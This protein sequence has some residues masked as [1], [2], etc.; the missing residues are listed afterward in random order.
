M[1]IYESHYENSWAICIG[2]NSYK[3]LSPLEFAVNDAEEIAKV[4]KEQFSFP[5]DNVKLLIDKNASKKQI[6]KTYLEL[7][8]KTNVN[9]KVIFFFAGHGHTVTGNR[10]EVGYL[11]PYDAT[12]NDLSSMIRWDEITKNS[13]LIPAKHILFLLDACF[14]G[15][16]ITR[17]MSSGNMRFVKDMLQRYSRQAL[18]AGKANQPVSDADGPI[19]HHS[20]FTGYLINGLKGEAK[21]FK[22]ILSANG[23]MHY[24]YQKVA[25]DSNSYQTPHYGFVD[26]DGDFIFHYPAEERKNDTKQE[27]ILFEV[28]SIS[29]QYSSNE[30]SFINKLKTY[31][32]ESKYLIKLD[33]LIT[34]ELKRALS[35]LNEANFKSTNGSITEEV[36]L[37]NIN[38]FE[39][40]LGNLQTILI[41]VSYW[42]DE[43]QKDL[44]LKIFSRLITHITN[45]NSQ[46]LWKTLR[47]YSVIWLLYSTGISLLSKNDLRT[48]YKLLSIETN[49]YEIDQ[50]DNTFLYSYSYAFSEIIS[51]KLIKVIKEHERHF[52]PLSEFLFT[53]LQS[54]LEDIIFIGSDYE[55][56]F[57]KY[58]VFV[59]LQSAYLH[60]KYYD[61]CWAP[62]GR[63]GWKYRNRTGKRNPVTKIIEL[64]KAQGNEWL[65]IKVGFFD[66]KYDNFIATSE[67]FEEYLKSLNWY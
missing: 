63:Y 57:D 15:L 11:I 41:A 14:S 27:D 16:A 46:F 28:P 47:W 52:A 21:S 42:G 50:E 58:E 5:E 19:P 54:K 23:L 36:L 62:T 1:L 56:F 4:L 38:K 33:D 2:I 45:E 9:D 55:I 39:S 66:S 64:G 13:E 53:K 60:I 59:G 20:V 67:K 10:G 29:E 24:V 34:D 17:S 43:N 49:T 12:Q 37:E 32:S 65:P 18:A 26:G 61:R 8:E 30:V 25:N 31:L 22:E 44:Y 51:H 3:N 48:L 6:L 40:I 7:T 35:E